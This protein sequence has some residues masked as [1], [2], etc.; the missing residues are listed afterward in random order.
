MFDEVFPKTIGIYFENLAMNSRTYEYHLT[1]AGAAGA[2]AATPEDV[3]RFGRV[4]Y[5]GRYLSPGLTE[6]MSENIGETVGGQYYGLAKPVPFVYG[7]EPREE[8]LVVPGKP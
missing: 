1:T 5:G 6:K 8:Y 2:V 4:L 7:A 3:V